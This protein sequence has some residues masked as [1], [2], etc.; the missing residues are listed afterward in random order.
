MQ[1]LRPRRGPDARG[2]GGGDREESRVIWAEVIFLTTGAE[3]L[4]T[5]TH[6]NFEPFLWVHN[7]VFDGRFGGWLWRPAGVR[8]DGDL[9]TGAGRGCS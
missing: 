5:S 7:W 1:A 6:D 9:F 2:F 3:K 4:P 8:G